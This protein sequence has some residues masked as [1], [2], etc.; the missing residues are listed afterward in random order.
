MKHSPQIP[1][2]NLQ[3]QTVWTGT[4]A[5]IHDLKKSN[6]PR[7]SEL[8]SE[9]TLLTVACISEL[10]KERI[11]QMA[12]KR[13]RKSYYRK[14]IGKKE[15]VKP[16]HTSN[17]MRQRDRE[18]PHLLD[19]CIFANLSETKLGKLLF[20]TQ[21]W[22]FSSCQNTIHSLFFFLFTYFD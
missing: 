7:G 12:R 10:F 1:F 14:T 3:I 18:I 6:S 20:E 16:E 4:L 17:H 13:L 8:F 19:Y 15:Q 11:Y 2:R 5:A 22:V 21:R 9:N